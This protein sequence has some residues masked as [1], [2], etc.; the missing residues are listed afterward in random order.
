MY[1][2]PIIIV[3]PLIIW[4]VLDENRFEQYN[5]QIV[6]NSFLIYATHFMVV[7]VFREINKRIVSATGDV[8]FFLVWIAEPIIYVIVTYYFCALFDWFIKKT[9]MA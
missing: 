2:Q 8:T 1:R 5:N 6:R 4:L 7:F 3:T 9:R